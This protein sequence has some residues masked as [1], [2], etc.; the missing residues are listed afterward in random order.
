MFEPLKLAIKKANTLVICAAAI[1]IGNFYLSSTQAQQSLGIAAVVNDE[2]IS[3]YDLNSRLTAV[4]AFAGLPDTPE[5]RRRIAAQVL[6][7]LIDERIKLQEANL[8]QITS[9]PREISDEKND[10]ERQNGMKPGQLKEFIKERGIQ[11]PSIDTQME[12]RSL[13]KRMVSTIFTR[14]ITITDEEVTETFEKLK[15]N[16]GKPEDLVFEI[17]LPISQP[18][19]EQDVT[20]LAERLIQQ[21]R[22]G[23]NFSAIAQ[24]FSQSSS[25]GNGG[26]LG[27]T[28]RGQHD[29]EL[30]QIISTLRPGQIAGPVRTQDGI[31]IVLLQATRKSRGLDGPPAGPEKVKLYQL[32]LALPPN[33]AAQL[34]TQQMQLAQTETRGL[35]GCV[36]MDT[37]A[38]KIGSPLSGEL[39]TFEISKISPQMQSLVKNVP[40]GQAS[41]PQQIPEGVIVLMVCERIVP[42]IKTRTPEQQRESIRR[43]LMGE[44][45]NLAAKRYIRDLRRASFIDVRLGNK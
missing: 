6:R 13:W 38:K 27:W 35:N 25:A 12:V 19:Q 40:T 5:T 9:S 18:D 22:G 14:G 44:R 1:A 20:R 45:L 32:H 8:L 42:K 24:N 15:N 16:K 34:I 28:L 41:A 4:I 33:P 17:F 39:G 10:L 37:L 31:Y 11:E 30:N 36:D 3:I 21:I 2:M 29:A 7:S 26:D 23:S 43:Q